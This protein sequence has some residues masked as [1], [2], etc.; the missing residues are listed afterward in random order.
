MAATKISD[1]AIEGSN[2]TEL[3]TTI[4][5]QRKGYN[6]ISLTNYDN[7]SL[8]AIAAGSYFEISGSLYGFTSEE[9]I[10]GTPS[11]GNINYIYINGTTFIPVWTT[12]APTW[13]DAKNGWYDAGETHR[14]VGGCYYDGT[15]YTRKWVYINSRDVLDKIKDGTTFESAQE[16]FYQI[17]LSAGGY[18]GTHS[19]NYLSLDTGYSD[20]FSVNLPHGAVVTGLYLHTSANLGS[21]GAILKRSSI[22][23]TSSQ[24]MAKKTSTGE[25]TNISYATIDNENYKYYLYIINESGSAQMI[26]SIRIR[27][28]ILEPKP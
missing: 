23:D 22:L 10:T 5:K 26:H 4:E 14:Y 18:D 1:Y 19:G 28:T 7:N 16:R 3:L 11:S 9:A 20:N 2:W 15:N 25:E 27:Y 12:T 6:G 8:P 21:N 13:S 24:E 17:P